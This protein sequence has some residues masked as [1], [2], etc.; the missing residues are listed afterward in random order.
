[1]LVWG[2]SL[3]GYQGP[4]RSGLEEYGAIMLFILDAENRGCGEGKI[5]RLLVLRAVFWRG[6]RDWEL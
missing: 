3:L 2:K 6:I 5:I 1:M 4:R